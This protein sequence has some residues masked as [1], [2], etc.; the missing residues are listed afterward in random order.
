MFFFLFCY[1]NLSF[2]EYRTSLGN[3]SP[4]TKGKLNK[5]KIPNKRRSSRKVTHSVFFDFKYFFNKL[6]ALR[7]IVIP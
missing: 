5:D 2:Y 1:L 7:L 4:N 6:L 3:S